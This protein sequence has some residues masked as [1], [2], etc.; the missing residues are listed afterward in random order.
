M[1]Y[2]TD[3]STR[4]KVFGIAASKDVAQTLVSRLLMQTVFG[5]VEQQ[6]R[7]A[8]LP[9][10]II[11]AILDQLS[12]RIIYEPLECRKVA[13]GDELTQNIMAKEMEKAHCI[14]VGSTVTAL[15]AEKEKAKD[16]CNVNMNMDID[17]VP[18]K[19]LSFSGVLMTSNT[20]MAN[21]SSDMWQS[22]VNRAIR[23][24]ASGPFASHFF[25]AFATVS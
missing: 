8:L 14:I 22:V 20:V 2:S 10:A 18:A 4:A 16:M 11:S 7:R 13:I 17:A 19:H 5:V 15:C 21:W 23:M 25:S 3:P 12:V 1:V 24:L 9:D 6:G